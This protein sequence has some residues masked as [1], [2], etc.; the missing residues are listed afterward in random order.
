MLIVLDRPIGSLSH[1]NTRTGSL[2]EVSPFAR[3]FAMRDASCMVQDTV[4]GDIYL[5]DDYLDAFKLSYSSREFSV[6]AGTNTTR[7]SDWEFNDSAFN[8]GMLIIDSGEQLLIALDNRIET[9][10]LLKNESWSLCSWESG[11][12]DH[13]IDSCVPQSPRSLM[14]L[15]HTLYVGGQG[16]IQKIQGNNSLVSHNTIGLLQLEKIMTL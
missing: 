15:N 7:F 11:E 16:G 10:Q 9:L 2:P 6:I 3:S 4:S 14:V 8:M 5:V 1:I 13:N 12:E